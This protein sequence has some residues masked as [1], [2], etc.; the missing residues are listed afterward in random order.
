MNRSRSRVLGAAV[1]LS[2]ALACDSPSDGGPT[3]VISVGPPGGGDR[4]VERRHMIEHQIAARGVTDPRVLEA[5][6]DVPRHLFVPPGQ[7]DHAYEDRPLPIGYGQ[8]ISQPYVVAFMTAA[9]ALKG[10]EK[11]LEI[12]TGSGYQAAVLAEVVGGAGRV[13]TIEIVEPLGRSGAKALDDCG[14][15]NVLTRIGDGYQGWAEEAP[16]DAVI[17]TAAPD[18]VPQPLTD[19][20]RVGGRLILP[21]GGFDQ[22]LVLLE[23]TPEGLDR[24]VVLGVRFVPMTGEAQ[25]R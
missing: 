2:A 23:K 8:T 15:H 17:L 13:Y 6:R 25:R 18:H 12:G 5:M 21:L 11:V 1:A 3:A 24:R 22:D 20:L 14:Y 16:F 9:L 19:Q 7:R 10:G 4:E